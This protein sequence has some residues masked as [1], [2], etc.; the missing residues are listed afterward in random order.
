LPDEVLERKFRQ[1]TRK[2]LGEE[3]AEEVIAL[4]RNLADLPDVRLLTKLL[5][6]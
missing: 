4:T 6:P 3:R 1:L 2:K 5:R